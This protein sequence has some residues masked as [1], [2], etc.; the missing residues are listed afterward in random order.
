MMRISPTLATG[1]SLLA[2]M[3]AAAEPV[4][5]QKP[6]SLPENFIEPDAGRMRLAALVSLGTQQLE[7]D[8]SELAMRTFELAREL[9]PLDPRVHLGL[10]RAQLIRKDSRIIVFQALERLFRRDNISRAIGHL[11]RAVELAPGWWEAH[12]WLASAY[13]RRFDQSDTEQ[14]LEHMS[15]AYELGG[16]RR[17]VI[18]KL[19]VLHKA[20]GDLE[21]A[22]RILR[23]AGQ[24]QDAAGDPV[25]ELELARVN[26]YR[27][28]YADGLRYYWKGVADLVT[29]E[30]MQPY[31]SDLA[32]LASKEEHEQYRSTTPE[33]AG[34]FFRAFWL[35]RDHE[36]G[37]SPGIRI[38]QHY[39][40]LQAADS[41]Y[42]VPFL[43]RSPSLHPS[44]AYLPEEASRYDDRGM[45]YI[46]HGP[47]ERVI[48]QLSEGLYPNESWIY[49][50]P[51]GQMVVNLVALK[52]NFDYQLVT[53]LTAAVRNYRG[54][55]S[56]IG[57]FAPEESYRIRW[58]TELYDSRMEVGGG[59]YSRLASRPYDPFSHLDEYEMNINSLRWALTSESVPYPY[60]ERLESSYDLAEFRGVNGGKSIVEFY[61]GVPGRA[62]TSLNT[63]T[64]YNFEIKSRIEL[65]DQAWERV[66]LY[67]Q[68]DRHTTTI[69]PHDLIDRQIV[70]LGRLELEP[71]DY[72]YFIRIGNGGAVGVFNGNLSVGS[73]REDSLQASQI[74]A[75]SVIFP[76]PADSGT[77]LRHGLEVQ[78]QPSR[79]FHAEQTLFAYQEI[80]NLVPD[81][82]GICNYRITYSMALLE[83]ERNVFG[84]IYDGFR[85]LVGARPGREKVI[86][87]VEKAKAPLDEDLVTEDLA[88]DISDNENGLYE[89]SIRID[90]L[91]QRG[92]SYR[93]NARFIVRD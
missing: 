19:A 56:G 87:T 39:T 65:Y 20:G 35:K 45:I 47:P 12:Y 60:T 43:R 71:G 40:R 21:N 10:G 15:R 54:V 53:S 26:F 64:G 33:Q 82:S 69:N 22:E 5:A 91:N 2:I 66:K 14:A 88:I 74:I 86:L 37:L 24:D 8:D 41:L 1:I 92:R 16:P 9:A 36:L 55:L 6:D 70:G 31:F 25:M 11:K 67:E 52:G 7:N 29:R 49:E 68:V 44:M 58:M 30:Q 38:I 85:T 27:A 93:R 78:P 57:H 48:T 23:K 34:E 13:M 51:G 59:V 62:I 50:R 17:E 18:L 73:Y 3:L 46:R 89:L 4:L 75:A 83:R 72:H 84:R 77:F 80:Y 63:G 76:S 90:D 28:K 61:S 81:T 32:M 42:R 79:T